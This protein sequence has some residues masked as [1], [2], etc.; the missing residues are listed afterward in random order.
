MTTA[1]TK[2]HLTAPALFSYGFRPFFLLGALW[3]AVAMIL[4]MA[5]LS[6]LVALP[7]RFEPVSWHAH[8]FLFGY[9]GAI[10]AGFLLTA[11]PN[12]TGRLPVTGWTLA[13]L[14]ALWLSGRIAVSLSALLPVGIAAAIDLVFPVVL[15]AVILR[16]IVAGK[17]WRNLFILVLLGV[18]T[19]ANLLFH[20]D[21]GDSGSAAQGPGLRLGV[22][23]IVILISLIG[24]RIVP[25]FTR[26]WLVKAGQR[27]LPTPPMQGFDKIVILAT[28]AALGMWVIAPMSGVTG[29]ALIG[30]GL[31]H[32]VRL[33][34]WRGHRTVSE[35]LLWVLHLGYAFIPVGAIAEGVAVLRPDMMAAGAAQHVWMVGGFGL[36]TLAVMCRATLGHTGQDLHAGP[37]G[38]LV[39]LCVIGSVSSR[40]AASLWPEAAMALYLVSGLF[41]IGAFGGF[42]I[43]YGPLLTR[44]KP[45]PT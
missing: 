18:F 21:P 35:P 31:L 23:A 28:I 40:I 11:I 5:L 32:L 9:L 8:E 10:I 6:G 25:S 22:A 16:E 39:F 43:V 3:A 4:W 20:M 38:V 29:F 1:E 37:A 26:N 27:D 45:S 36:M 19:L 12:W 14:V 34:R 15:G 41:W 24:G 42:V 2:R 7:T 33:S 30:V 17:N 44:P 13:G